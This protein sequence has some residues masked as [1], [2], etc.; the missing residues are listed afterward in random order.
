MS[1]GCLL[2]HPR[3]CGRDTTREPYKGP[4]TPSKKQAARLIRQVLC[5]NLG[6]IC[7]ALSVRSWE[8]YR[9]LAASRNWQTQGCPS[10][11]MIA[12]SYK[13]R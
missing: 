2:W 7:A 12:A 6:R 3:Y 1:E 10:P 5:I 9:P 4:L 13:P 8:I 11:S